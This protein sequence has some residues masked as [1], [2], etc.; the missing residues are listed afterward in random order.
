MAFKLRSKSDVK[1]KKSFAFVEGS[2]TK[3]GRKRKDGTVVT[4]KDGTSTT[5]LT[6]S[7]KGAKYAAELA[8]GV[9]ITNDGDFKHGVDGSEIVLTPEQRAYRAGFLDS[10]KESAKAYKAKKSGGAK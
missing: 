9:K 7:G 10:Q 3:S 1:S 6:P 4:F 5:L 2:K 8:M